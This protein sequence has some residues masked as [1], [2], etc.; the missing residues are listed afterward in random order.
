MRLAKGD[1]SSGV[2][3]A[4]VAFHDMHDMGHSKG[5]GSLVVTNEDRPLA[6]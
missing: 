5:D 2:I 3:I 1:C 4:L 6:T